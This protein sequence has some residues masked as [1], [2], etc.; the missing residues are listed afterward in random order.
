MGMIIICSKWLS[1]E[2]GDVKKKIP[3]K[4]KQ[5]YF[6]GVEYELKTCHDIFLIN[7]TI[8]LTSPLT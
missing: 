7:G 3:I 4:L 2:L 6:V 8:L 1:G 5:L